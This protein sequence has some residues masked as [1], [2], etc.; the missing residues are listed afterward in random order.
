MTTLDRLHGFSLVEFKG[1]PEE[2]AIKAFAIIEHTVLLHAVS[3]Q[4]DTHDRDYRFELTLRDGTRVDYSDEVCLLMED[5]SPFSKEDHTIC[6][7]GSHIPTIIQ[8]E[9]DQIPIS[10]IAEI[11]VTE[12]H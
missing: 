8:L 9:D 3:W 10:N 11:L 2:D 4:T 6:L 1:N 7:G 5:G 12:N